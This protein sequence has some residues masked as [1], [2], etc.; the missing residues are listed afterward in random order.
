MSR[1]INAIGNI[2]LLPK[3]KAEA[4]LNITESKEITQPKSLQDIETTQGLVCVVDNG[5]FEAAAFIYNNEEFSAFTLLN[6]M[7]KKRW[8]VISKEVAELIA[9]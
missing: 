9:D 6:D 5:L 4:I 1:Y 7:R 8:I 2:P 3:G